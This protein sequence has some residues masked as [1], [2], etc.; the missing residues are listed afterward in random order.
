VT[1]AAKRAAVP[2]IP[3]S[4]DETGSSASLP[5]WGGLALDLINT[6]MLSRGK[7]H[8]ALS[9]P[10][11][12]AYWWGDAC[13]QYPD[14]CVV[15][16]AREPTTWTREMLDAVKALRTA[17]R[18]LLAQVVEQHAIVEED[19]KPVNDILAQGYSALARTTQGGVRAI[20]HQRDPEKSSLLFP[21][22]LSAL[23]LFTECDWQRLHQCKSDRC[24]LYFY[25]TTKSGTRRWCSPGCMNRARSIHQYQLSKKER[26]LHQA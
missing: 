20:M 7:K 14:E 23:H 4:G 22:A 10:A 19:L 8:D 2:G 24:I 3:D 21:I 11:A 6:E 12:L 15:E 13:R 9:T 25:D 17:L 16:G 1:R 18:A 26:S 5:V